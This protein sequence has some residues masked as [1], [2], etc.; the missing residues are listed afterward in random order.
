MT[1]FLG[2]FHLALDIIC[3]VPCVAYSLSYIDLNVFMF[4]AFFSCSESLIQ[5]SG[6][7]LVKKIL[8][9]SV[10]HL[11]GIIF[12]TSKDCLVTLTDSSP[13]VLKNC[14]PSTLSQLCIRVYTCIRSY[15]IL[16]C[17]SVCIFSS[18]SRF[19]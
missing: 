16:R 7:L 10:L 1:Y 15:H 8:Q 18:F 4:L 11:V 3:R 5:S 19:S 17:S 6:T 2:Y 9:T 12:S 14:A 13:T